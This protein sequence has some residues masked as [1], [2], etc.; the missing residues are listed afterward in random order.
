MLAQAGGGSSA[1]ELVMKG[2]PDLCAPSLVPS[3]GALCLSPTS[4]TTYVDREGVSES[5]PLVAALAGTTG[6]D[7]GESGERSQ[8]ARLCCGDIQ[9]S[10]ESHRG[11]GQ[12][13]DAEQEP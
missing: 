10:L 9:R 3:P 11:E 5:Y 6:Q 1:P 13:E 7:Q 2:S 8:V 12:G 4:L